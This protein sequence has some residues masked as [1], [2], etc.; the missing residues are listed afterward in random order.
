MPEIVI[1]LTIRPAILLTEFVAFAPRL[2]KKKLSR[3][4]A[5]DGAVPP[6]QLAAVLQLAFP[7]PPTQLNVAGAKRV[8]SSST[9]NRKRGLLFT[10]VVP[11]RRRHILLTHRT[12]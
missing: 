5:A 9:A 6:C 11:R 10:M 2:P 4:E 12:R 8:S 7:A 3:V 1:E